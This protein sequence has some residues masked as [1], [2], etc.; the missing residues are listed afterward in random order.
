MNSFLFGTWVERQ[1]DTGMETIT[2]YI[3]ALGMLT[4]YASHEPDSNEALGP[5][6]PTFSTLPGPWKA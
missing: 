5:E 6:L 1:G 2:Q 3:L 4:A